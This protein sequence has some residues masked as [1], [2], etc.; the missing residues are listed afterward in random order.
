VRSHIDLDPTKTID[1]ATIGVEEGYRAKDRDDRNSEVSNALYH[2]CIRY[3]IEQGITT[4][5]A[6]LDNKVLEVI[7]LLAEPFQSY[8]GVASGS[9]LNSPLSTPVWCDLPT[10][11]ER[12]KAYDKGLYEMFVEGTALEGNTTMPDRIEPTTPESS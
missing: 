2:A 6:I 11:I 9:Y 7:Q 8:D 5:V 3:S 1:I 4:W 10:S 12:L